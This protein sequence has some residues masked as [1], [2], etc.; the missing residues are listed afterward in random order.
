MPTVRTEDVVF[1]SYLVSE[2]PLPLPFP[3]P[4]VTRFIFPY[5]ALTSALACTLACTPALCVGSHHLL[6]RVK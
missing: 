4:H 1:N 3:S 5:H 6:D 2:V